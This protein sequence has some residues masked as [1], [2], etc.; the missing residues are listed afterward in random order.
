MKKIIV[1]LA[2]A[3]A[4]VSCTKES[5]VSKDSEDGKEYTIGIMPVGDISAAYSP[6]TKAGNS[7]TTWYG[8]NIKRDGSDYLVGLYD[9][10]SKFK[11]QLSTEHSYS[12]EITAIRSLVDIIQDVKITYKASG[13][14]WDAPL[15]G[16]MFCFPFNL[17]NVNYIIGDGT[18]EFARVYLST[19]IADRSSVINKLLEKVYVTD[20]SVVQFNSC[21]YYSFRYS[22]PYLSKGNN[23]NEWYRF[24]GTKNNF[25][26]SKDETL[27]FT[28]KHEGFGLQYSVSGICDGS[29]SVIIDNAQTDN[30]VTYFSQPAITTNYTS[31]QKVIEFRDMTSETEQVKVTVVWTRGNNVVDNLGS[32]TVN[33]RRNKINKINITLGEHSS[34]KSMSVSTDASDYFGNESSNITI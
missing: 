32:T 11:V 5:I 30:N 28:L 6:L 20:G 21:P 15:N 8:I 31:P 3:I 1:L 25:T 14:S 12:F 19:G 9:D 34:S 33:V 26:P 17:M 29:V 24:Y 2:I 7:E 13:S 16:I 18:L 27:P 22:F 10:I 4:I 23:S